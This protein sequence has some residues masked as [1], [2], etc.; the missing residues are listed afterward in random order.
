MNLPNYLQASQIRAQF[1]AAMSQMYRKEVPKYGTLLEIVSDLNLQQLETR[2][3]FIQPLKNTNKLQHLS[4]ERHGAIRLGTAEELHTMRRL[5]AV[6]GMYPV[7]YYDL[8]EAG[9]PV[10]STA[11]RPVQLMH[12]EQNPFRMFTSLLR[13]D[14]IEDAELREQAK[15]LLNQREIFTA[16][17]L[18][19]IDLFETQHGL[20]ADQA[21]RF[22]KEVL[23]T[24]RWHQKATVDKETYQKLLDTHGLLADIVCFNGP[25]INH[26][27]PRTLDIDRVEKK[28]KEVGLNTKA[29]IEGPPKRLYPIL[30]RQTSFTALDESIEFKSKDDQTI[31]GSHTA[32]FG[33]VEQRGMAL[34]PKG[35][36]L[37]DSLLNKVREEVADVHNQVELYYKKLEAIFDDFPDDLEQLRVQGL[38]YF[39]YQ[40]R[41][42]AIADLDSSLQALIDVGMLRYTPITYEDFLPVSAAGIFK[43]NLGDNAAQDIQRSPNQQDF[44]QALGCPVINEFEVYQRIQTDSLRHA[45]HQLR[46]EENQRELLVQQLPA[47]KL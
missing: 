36:A 12:L 33:E 29:V 46:L 38:G 47:Y 43:S 24:F 41:E 19:L 4:E 11:F 14:L 40:A 9:I 17:A 44:E 13:L 28:M 20:T 16:E 10:H 15:T 8:S 1:T 23:E 25:H 42:G 18:E 34:T 2:T 30:L 37:Y 7:G 26:L 32:R 21:E 45:L 27:T 6:M 22:I 3:G 5:F 35:R 39:I 31:T